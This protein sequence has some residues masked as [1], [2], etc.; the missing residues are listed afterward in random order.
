MKRL[1]PLMLMVLPLVAVA[2]ALGLAG[3]QGDG[4]AVPDGQAL[5]AGANWQPEPVRLV[6]GWVMPAGA[7]QRPEFDVRQC[8]VAGELYDLLPAKGAVPA[9]QAP[10]FTTAA[11]ADWLAPD[12]PVLG[13]KVG[14]ESHCYPLA[15]LNW[16]SLVN[17]KVGG[18]A[19]YVLWDPPSGAAL[20]RRVGLASRPL[21]IAGLGWRG[22]GLAY[23]LSTGALWDLL[24]GIPLSAP[25]K[26]EPPAAKPDYRWLPLERMTWAA[27]RRL[28]GNT[29]VLS[30]D[31][32]AD[33]DYSLDP[34]TTAALG[35]G[36]AATN[37]WTNEALLA[38]D[39]LRDATQ[40]L[41][42]K[43]WVVGFLAGTE[44][45]AAPL[46]A[47]AEADKREAVITTGAGQY[48]VRAWPG[49]DRFLVEAAQGPPPAQIRLLWFAWKA[50]FPETKVWQP[51]PTAAVAATD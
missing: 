43:E 51:T 9:L 3:S 11:E 16:H 12:A 14:D 33:F 38:P 40:T 7:R 26:T 10:R 23:D 42:D 48:T 20:A 19:V 50:R 44:A 35:A 28:H 39:S 5:V 25:D 17:D 49:D 29:L 6:N 34:Y 1:H 41:P 15:I 31:T 8:P 24:G 30:R 37:Y 18:Q 21:G 46:R 32:G 4:M 27:W 2:V 22:M 47:V 45:W 36:G 13:L